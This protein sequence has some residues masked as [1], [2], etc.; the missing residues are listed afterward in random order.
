MLNTERDS[1]NISRNYNYEVMF[2]AQANRSGK[3]NANVLV[4]SDILPITGDESNKQMFVMCG[5][6]YGDGSSCVMPV[7][8]ERKIHM[9]IRVNAL[10]YLYLNATGYR[11]IGSN[12]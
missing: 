5:N 8:S 9:I 6:G 10:S 11:R 12:S 4:Y 7:G 3:E 2:S 1:S